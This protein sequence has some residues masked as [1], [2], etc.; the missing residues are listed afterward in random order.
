VDEDNLTI[1]EWFG[2]GLKRSVL[3]TEFK[4]WESFLQKCK[5]VW[6]I[7]CIYLLIRLCKKLI[8]ILDETGFRIRINSIIGMNNETWLIWKDWEANSN[9]PLVKNVKKCTIWIYI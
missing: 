7:S 4:D 1:M 5:A 8:H 2:A 3:A 9:C 6:E